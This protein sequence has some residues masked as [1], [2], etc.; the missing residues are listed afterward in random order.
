MFRSFIFLSLISAL[1]G[2]AVA[3]TNNDD[4]VENSAAQKRAIEN[5]T[6]TASGFEQL[7]A[8]PAQSKKQV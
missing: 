1:F 2:T 8:L 5:I 7:T 6:V 4:A 3:Q